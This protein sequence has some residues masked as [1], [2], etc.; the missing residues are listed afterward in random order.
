MKYRIWIFNMHSQFT[1]E[2]RTTPVCRSDRFIYSGR[3]KPFF[4]STSTKKDR[5]LSE[6]WCAVR[7]R[8]AHLSQHLLLFLR[9]RRTWD[10]RQK[11]GTMQSPACV[12]P[13]AGA[14]T[15]EIH[16]AATGRQ[17][18]LYESGRLSSRSVWRRRIALQTSSIWRRSDR[19]LDLVLFSKPVNRRSWADDERMS[20][21]RGWSDGEGFIGKEARGHSRIHMRLIRNQTSIKMELHGI[22]H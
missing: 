9:C 19:R 17:T 6:A 12:C 1:A 20:A 22:P 7:N 2:W 11:G 3:I 18:H 10:I 13:A 14:I 4:R 8:T 21:G 5:H 16:T 15:A